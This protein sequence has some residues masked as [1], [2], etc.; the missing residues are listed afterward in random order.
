[1]AAVGLPSVAP[2]QVRFN[3]A[4]Y[5]KLIPS[6]APSL[7]VTP[8]PT[9]PLNW[10]PDLRS[11]VYL[12]EFVLGN[13]GP[14]NWFLQLQAV[15]AMTH[16]PNETPAILDTQLTAVLNASPDR[17]DRFA[18]IIHQHDA[19]G[20]ISYFLG[21]LMIDPARHPKTYLLI[22]VARRIGELVTMMLK[23]QP[24]PGVPMVPRPSQWCPAIVPMIDPPVTPSFPAGH[25]LEARLI[26]ES[27][28]AAWGQGAGRKSRRDLLDYLA[29]RLGENRIIAGLHFPRDIAAGDAVALACY[30]LMDKPGSQFHQLVLDA[31]AES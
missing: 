18:E 31:Q 20:A 24:N 12:N 11:Y 13:V 27:L 30:P 7:A 23:N 22:R 19:E 26:A 4:D 5:R 8:A 10:D 1:M 29:L 21:M 17:D 25:A 2:A 15:P 28:K 16:P 6:P 3:T 14:P 9:F